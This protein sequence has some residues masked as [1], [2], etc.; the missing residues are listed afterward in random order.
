VVSHIIPMG[1]Q[2]TISVKVAGRKLLFGTEMM[3]RRRL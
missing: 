3:A 1:I 2:S